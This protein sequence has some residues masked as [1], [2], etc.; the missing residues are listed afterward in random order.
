[1]FRK[2]LPFIL[3]AFLVLFSFD[4]V[5]PATAQFCPIGTVVENVR[6][7]DADSKFSVRKVED[8]TDPKLVGPFLDG[9]IMR[10][11]LSPDT[12]PIDA[13]HVITLDKPEGLI[14]LAISYRGCYVASRGVNYHPFPK[15]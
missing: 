6:E 12:L 8:Y 2:I 14:I 1:M 7:L 13:V 5:Q 4:W 15:T 9:E 10:G 11:A 3:A